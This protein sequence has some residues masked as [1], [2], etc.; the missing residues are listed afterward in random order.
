MQQISLQTGLL[1][2]YSD[3]P[4]QLLRLS[5]FASRANKKRG[6]VFVSKLLGKHY[7]S[8]PMD[9]QQAQRELAEKLLAQ[10]SE[11]ATLLIGFAETATGI[12]FGVFEQLQQLGFTQ[13][14]YLHTTR[15]RLQQELWLDFQEEHSH[16]TE[17]L[18][19]KPVE[20]KLRAQLEKV[21]NL[22][23]LDD[24]FSTGNTL[25]NLLYALQPQ[26]PALKNVYGAALLSWMPNP[27]TDLHCI[28]LHQGRFEFV[29]KQTTWTDATAGA[30]ARNPPPLDEI[31][32]YN[33]GRFGSAHFSPD[34][35]RWIDW[36][37]LLNQR[38]LVLG[39]G[40]F[41]HP[42]FALGRFLQQQGVDVWVQ[43]TTRSP[44]NVDADIQNR[45]CFFDNYHENIYNYLYNIHN[46]DKIVLCTE[47]TRL[48]KNFDLPQQLADY[49]EAVLLAE[50][51]WLN[52]PRH[53]ASP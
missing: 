5:G 19:Y 36:K 6:F 41:M 33:F 32:P 38:V 23:L 39:T 31:I 28:C 24:E 35:A 37:S 2:I 44:L 45:L 18:L 50:A 8:R 29:P 25:R 16:A 48:P 27:P 46:Y 14:F 43:S 15:Y 17:H 34:Y 42:A 3:A 9:M 11:R 52:P 26:L 49:A 13:A 47:T 51:H 20:A 1:S 30:V 10:L 7:P 21:E 40:E 12:G 4:E 22:V 53:C